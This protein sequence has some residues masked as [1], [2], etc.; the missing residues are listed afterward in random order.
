MNAQSHWLL[1]NL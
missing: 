1:L